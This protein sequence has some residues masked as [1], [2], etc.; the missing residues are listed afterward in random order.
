M[1]FGLNNQQHLQLLDLVIDPLKMLGITVYVF[2]S[3]VSGKHHPFSD[4]DILYSVPD[5]SYFNSHI[6]VIKESI[7]ESNFP[8]KVDLVNEAELAASYRDSVF[9]TRV[10]V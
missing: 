6:H 10:P 9:R 4:I 1:K 5:G 3:R 2:G 7:E 8:I